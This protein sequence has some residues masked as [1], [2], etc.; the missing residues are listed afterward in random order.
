MLWLDL[1][2]VVCLQAVPKKELPKSNIHYL[3]SIVVK[4][5]QEHSENPTKRRS[6]Y[7]IIYIS[8]KGKR[9]VIPLS[10]VKNAQ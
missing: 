9:K 2:Q 7:K 4:P 10:K 1:P 5:N 3:E 6:T 8:R